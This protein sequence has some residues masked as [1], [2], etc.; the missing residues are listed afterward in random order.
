V[1]AK[2]VGRSSPVVEVQLRDGHVWELHPSS[3]VNLAL[4]FI[5]F[6]SELLLI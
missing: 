2:L 4:H 6:P 5:L 1:E 3:P